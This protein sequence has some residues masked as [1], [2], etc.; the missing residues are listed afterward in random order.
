[1]NRTMPD[2]MTLYDTRAAWYIMKCRSWDDTIKHGTTNHV[3]MRK[4]PFLTCLPKPVVYQH[5]LFLD[6]TTLDCRGI[7]LAALDAVEFPRWLKSHNLWDSHVEFGGGNEFYR[8]D[9]PLAVVR[10]FLTEMG[11]PIVEELHED[12]FPYPS[13]HD[14]RNVIEKEIAERQKVCKEYLA[15]LQIQTPSSFLDIPS[16]NFIDDAVTKENIIRVFLAEGHEL[17]S[18]QSD[19]YDIW[20]NILN[21]VATYAGILQWPTGT[22]K[23]IGEIILILLTF[24]HVKSKGQLYRGLLIAPKN[25]ILNTQ[26]MTLRK[27]SQFGLHIVEAHDSQYRNCIIPIDK[28]ILVI[29]THAALAKATGE[30]VTEFDED[31]YLTGMDRL[32]A[33]THIHYDEGHRITAEKFLAALKRK[34]AQWVTPYITAT[35]ATPKTSNTKQHERLNE[36][37]GGDVPILHRVDIETAVT[38]GWIAKPRFHIAEIPDDIA[39]KQVLAVVTHAIFLMEKRIRMNMCKGGK[40]IV[41]LQ[42]KAEVAVAVKQAQ[43]IFPSNYKIYWAVDIDGKSNH[44]E[45]VSAPADSTPRIMIACD[46]YREGSDIQGLE[47]TAVLMGK[48]MAAYILVQ[49]IGRALRVDYEGKEGW[50]CILRP[51]YA[52]DK[53]TSVLEHILLDLE[54]II[55]FNAGI[56]TRANVEAFVRTYFGNITIDG[57]IINVNETIERVQN[58]YLRRLQNRRE[59]SIADTRRICAE[60]GIAD[61]A[62]YA[63]VQSEVLTGLPVE[64]SDYWQGHGWTNWYDFLH[65]QERTMTLD[66]FIHDIVNERQILVAEDWQ[67]NHIVGYPTLQ[68]ICDGYFAQ[69]NIQQ[70]ADILKHPLIIRSKA[71]RR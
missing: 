6:M 59:M 10:R 7:S 19:L 69:N 65:G 1:M 25:D 2:I 53:D 3:P 27:L 52:D 49:I 30:Y 67:S 13:Q 14:S 31:I 29:V 40:A 33:M 26:L 56:A 4:D 34:R 57:R 39:E 71:A 44:R 41:Y 70:Y 43:D 21:T 37:F 68:D 46:R 50:C 32:P 35:S 9:D 47:F 48:T 23:T 12:I 51:K 60:H 66:C 17:R 54:A 36:F 15:S 64:P 24:A 16:A 42:S 28:H 11:V 18:N 20:L 8:Q 62:H 5:I 55:T 61:S 22:G 63:Q 58:M 45:F 38:N